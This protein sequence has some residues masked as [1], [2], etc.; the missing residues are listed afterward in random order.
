MKGIF[1]L[2]KISF[3]GEELSEVKK[4]SLYD[5]ILAKIELHELS[6]A[7]QLLFHLGEGEIIVQGEKPGWSWSVQMLARI[8]SNRT[9]RPFLFSEPQL[10]FLITSP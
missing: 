2:L 5:R 9:P 1:E 3:E 10:E 8:P 4:E 7:E 6:H